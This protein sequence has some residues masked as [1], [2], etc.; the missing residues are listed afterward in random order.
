MGDANETDV[1][2]SVSFAV[3]E[4]ADPGDYAFTVTARRSSDRRHE[5]GTGERIVIRAAGNESG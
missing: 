5:N 4:G 1:S 2:G 3:A